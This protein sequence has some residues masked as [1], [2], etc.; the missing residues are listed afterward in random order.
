VRVDG[1][2][3]LIGTE[4]EVLATAEYDAIALDGSPAYCGHRGEGLATGQARA[5]GTL[6][7]KAAGR[8]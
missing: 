2:W 5:P 3:G 8:H 7:R 4:G 6:R 1:K